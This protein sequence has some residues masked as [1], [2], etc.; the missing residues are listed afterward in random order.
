M[1]ER[2]IGQ[3]DFVGTPRYVGGMLRKIRRNDVDDRYDIYATK[4]GMTRYDYLNMESGWKGLPTPDQIEEWAEKLDIKNSLVIELY[5]ASKHAAPKERWDELNK[6]M[7]QY[8][9]PSYENQDSR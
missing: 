6:W 9:N 1:P 2:I 3:A 5:G 7:K 4:L 8:F